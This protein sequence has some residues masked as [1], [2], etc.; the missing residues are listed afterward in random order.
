VIAEYLSETVQ[1]ERKRDALP[2]PEPDSEI[3][4]THRYG[5]GSARIAGVQVVTAAGEPVHGWAPNQSVF[6]RVAFRACEDLP[7]PI[8]GFLVRNSRGETLFG[9]NTMRE[10]YPMPSIAPGNINRVD[11]HFTMPELASGRY[12]IS[13]AISEGTLDEFGVCDYVE[14]ALA[15]D[16][17]GNTQGYLKLRC[18]SVA[19]RAGGGQ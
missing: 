15:L 7:V 18:S 10:N 19:L 11:F 12:F 3:A 8:V 2:L 16:A 6:L 9:S 4:G 14:D 13:V 1:R 17:A 5:S